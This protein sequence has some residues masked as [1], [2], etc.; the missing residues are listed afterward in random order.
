MKNLLSFENVFNV[1][2]FIP[3]WGVCYILLL[4]LE[5]SS[6]EH[7][8]ISGLLSY[9]KID[10]LVNQTK[11]ENKIFEIKELLNKKS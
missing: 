6:Q 4:G 1:I 3:C 10:N 9:W 7:F 5:L 11:L 2:I 8:I